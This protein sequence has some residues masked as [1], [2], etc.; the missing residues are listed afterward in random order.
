MTERTRTKRGE[1]PRARGPTSE[2]DLHDNTRK[3][4]AALPPEEEQVLRMRLTGQTI[5]QAAKQ[6]GMTNSQISKIKAKA[7][8]KLGY[9]P[10]V[11]GA[12]EKRSG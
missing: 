2:I 7:R 4:L 11:G 6:L 8:R 12:T 1:T 10:P 9:P 3:L 5:G